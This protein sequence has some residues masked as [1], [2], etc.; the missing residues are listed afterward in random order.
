MAMR[1]MTGLA[2]TATFASVAGCGGPKSIAPEV[3]CL[4]GGYRFADGALLGL[5]PRDDGDIRYVFES[6]VTGVAHELAPL[7][8]STSKDD[9][10]GEVKLLFKG[11]ESG[12]L[13]FIDAA[14]AAAQGERVPTIVKETVFEGVDGKRAGRLVLPAQGDVKAIVVS[15]HGSERWSGRTGDRLQRLLPA[16]GIGVFVYDKRGTGL[17]EGEYTQDFEI[18][19]GDAIR[20]MEEAR[21]LYGAGDARFGYFGGSQG[22][23][24]APLATAKAGAD[25][26]IAAYGLA[27][28]PLAEDR[29]QVLMDLERAGYGEVEALKARRLIEATHRVMASDFKDG[30]EALAAVKREFAGEPWLDAVEGEFTGDFARTPNWAIRIL[31]GFFDVGTSWDYDP[32]AALD[33][34]EVPHLWIL[35]EKDREAPHENTLRILKEIQESRPNLDIVVFP[36]ADHG[37]WEFVEDEKG[38][39]RETRYADGYYALV[40]NFVLTGEPDPGVAGPAVFRGAR[41]GAAEAISGEA[42]R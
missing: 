4:M 42:E 40:R 24:V 36:D 15:V 25:F 20:A 19:S 39:R 22:G 41:P 34:V 28:S 10:G 5:V 31:G 9:P 32:R 14:G 27:E 1:L 17:S 30:W 21:R 12:T 7:I 16:S 3:D 38:V 2:I 26:V 23:W 37:I 11:C 35:G 29:E 18:L 13:T 6:G 8:W 33:A